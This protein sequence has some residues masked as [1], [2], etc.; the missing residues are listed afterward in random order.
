MKSFTL[1]LLLVFISAIFA[2]AEENTILESETSQKDGLITET[3]TEKHFTGKMQKRYK[4]KNVKGEVTVKEGKVIGSVV[5]DKNGNKLA[6]RIEGDK[7]IATHYS[8]EIK[9]RDTIS[10][11]GETIQIIQWY[12]NG[13][14]RQEINFKN[15]KTNGPQIAW[16]DNGQ[17]RRIAHFKNGSPLVGECKKWNKDGSIIKIAKPNFLHINNKIMANF[18]QLVSGN[19]CNNMGCNH[20]KHVSG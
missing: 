6:F 5:V 13:K 1:A 10:I 18:I 14:K 2:N 12:P 3:A 17:M 8:R 7:T 16:Y 15:R 9:I 19:T 20:I 11:D 4:D